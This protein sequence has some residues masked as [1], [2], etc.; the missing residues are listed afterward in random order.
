MRSLLFVPGDSERK[1]AKALTAGAD[2]LI[3]D[4]ED[5]VAA[6]RKV[7]A[8]AM[9]LE[10]VRGLPTGVRPRIYVRINSMD[11]GYWEADA[12]ALTAPGVD[13]ILL[14]KTR[15]GEDVHRL[16][17]TLGHLEERAGVA[18]GTIRITAIAT[19]VAI[20]LL[21]MKSYI[22][23]STRLEALTWG[24]EDLSADIGASATREPDGQF[25]SPFRL[26]RDLCL[27]TAIA[28]GIEPL[29]TVYPNFR[30]MAGFRRECEQSARDGFTGKLAIHPDQVAPINEIFGLG[31]SEIAR[32]RT[33][34]DLFAANPDAGVVSYNGEMLDRPHLKLA[35]RVLARAD[36]A[37]GSMR[38]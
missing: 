25:T 5:S 9:S 27:F 18:P 16:S 20:S 24:A 12:A 6:D 38:R 32:A 11:T 30:D 26:A 34:V 28:A 22:G 3:L 17:L 7:T 14:P 19:E 21:D 31:E 23:S 33:I 4:L 2:A 29:D 37:R 15:S 10:F 35:E 1:L 36:K 8:R 13:A